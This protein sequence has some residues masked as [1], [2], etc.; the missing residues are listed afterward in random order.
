MKAPI[1]FFAA[2]MTMAFL[3]IP[4]HAEWIEAQVTSINTANQTMQIHRLDQRGKSETMTVKLDKNA[5]LQGYQGVTD[6]QSGDRVRMDVDSSFMGTK[7]AKAINASAAAQA[8]VN[9]NRAARPE[10][11]ARNNAYSANAKTRANTAVNTAGSR[12]VGALQSTEDQRNRRANADA[13][14]NAGV[15]AEGGN[16]NANASTNAAASLNR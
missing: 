6:V 2:L 9:R 1:A 15:R 4:A 16:T 13:N 8:S 10:S 14:L 7:T 5:R 3:P 11:T 12:A